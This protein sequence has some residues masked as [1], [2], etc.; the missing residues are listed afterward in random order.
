LLAQAQAQAKE[1][2]LSVTKHLKTLQHWEAQWH[3]FEQICTILKLMHQQQGL[4]LVIDNQGQE[5][6]TKEEVEE[7][8]L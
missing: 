6:T 1:K 4:T 2:V 8:C 5:C 7:A 3:V